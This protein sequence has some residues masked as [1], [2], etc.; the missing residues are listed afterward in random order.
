MRLR[1][2][3]ADPLSADKAPSSATN[4]ARDRGTRVWE[5]L[6]ALLL[7][8]AS[9]GCRCGDRLR[10]LLRISGAL[11]TLRFLMRLCSASGCERSRDLR[12]A[13]QGGIP[14]VVTASGSRHRAGFMISLPRHGVDG[15]R[16]GCAASLR[17][18]RAGVASVMPSGSL[19]VSREDRGEGDGEEVKG[20]LESTETFWMGASSPARD[21]RR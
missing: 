6:L 3:Q 2:E 8:L 19:L 7:A 1:F 16:G 10:G 13:C 21:P 14:R 15:E 20:R 9:C 17:R 11:K 5:A 4:V 12:H 18:P